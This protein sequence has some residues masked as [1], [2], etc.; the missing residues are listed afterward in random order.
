VADRVAFFDVDGTLLPPPSSERRFVYWLLAHRQIGLYHMVRGGLSIVADVF[1]SVARF[2]ANKA[3]LGGEPVDRFSSLGAD[4]VGSH[5][6]PAL[7]KSA[8]EAI[9]QH[10]RQGERVI[11]L[12][13]SLDLLMRP[14]AKQLGVDDAISGRLEESGGRF[15]GRIIP[16]HPYGEGKAAALRDYAQQAAIDLERACFYSDSWSDLPAF[17]LVGRAIVVNPSPRLARLAGQRGWTV[18]RWVDV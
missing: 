1:W 13:G 14:L 9:K 12:T 17:R 4:Y 15:T 7:R 11:L 3:Y 10:R 8:L 16:P 18:A 2:K 5:I 6:L